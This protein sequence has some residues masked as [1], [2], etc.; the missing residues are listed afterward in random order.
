MEMIEGLKGNVLVVIVT[1]ESGPP[2]REAG[3]AGELQQ[4]V[5]QHC[6]SSLVSF[7]PSTNAS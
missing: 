1:N 7:V 5:Y 2:S 3:R 4:E 6:T